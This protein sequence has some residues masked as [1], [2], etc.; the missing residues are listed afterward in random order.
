MQIICDI[1][2]V[3]K[4]INFSSEKLKRC[5]AVADE[6]LFKAADQHGDKSLSTTVKSSDPTTK[7][8]AYVESYR[9]FAEVRELF[10]ELIYTEPELEMEQED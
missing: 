10:E 9:C 7:R 2:S 3:Q 6:R 5:E 8:S 4:Q 1:R